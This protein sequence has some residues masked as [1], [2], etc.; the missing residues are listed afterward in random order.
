MVACQTYVSANWLGAGMER[1]HADVG[2]VAVNRGEPA[3]FVSPPRF[4][5]ARRWSRAEV[6]ESLGSILRPDRPR[7]IV[8][9]DFRAELPPASRR[10]RLTPSLTGPST[11][12]TFA[13]ATPSPAQPR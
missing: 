12:S 9:L 1:E 8:A 5:R 10:T 7:P 13:V 11:S 3:E 6:R 4:P 2:V